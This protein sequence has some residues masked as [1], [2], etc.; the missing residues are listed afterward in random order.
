MTENANVQ[1]KGDPFTRWPTK[2]DKQWLACLTQNQ[3]PR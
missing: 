2:Q 1:K 3:R